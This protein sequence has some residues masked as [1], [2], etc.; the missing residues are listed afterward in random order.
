M[1][2]KGSGATRRKYRINSNFRRQTVFLITIAGHNGEEILYMPR[3][4]TGTYRSNS[5]LWILIGCVILVGVAT[6]VYV[7]PL[8]GTVA[9]V[10]DSKIT[11]AMLYDEM[12]KRVGQEALNNLIDS[13]LIMQ[14]ASMK[15]LTL[16][17]AELKTEVDRFILEQYGSEE[18]FDEVLSYYGLTR[19]QAEDEWKV[20][21][22]AKKVL[23]AGME[24]T[25][26]DLRAYFDEHK[27]DFDEEELVSLRQ[28]VSISETDAQ[29]ILDEVA[30]GGDFAEIA[31]EKSIDAQTRDLGG[32]MGWVFR[33]GLD[34][35]LGQIAFELEEGEL[36]Q[37]VETEDGWVI[38][39]VTGHK[40]ARPAVFEDVMEEV[41]AQYE[42]EKIDEALPQWLNGLRSKAQVQYK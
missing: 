6:V 9:V 24:I 10:N 31:K 11:K 39:E 1:G 19:K 5:V 14:E 37:P 22:S 30:Q 23:L 41:R 12:Y 25:E 34:E 18:Q 15:N 2:W 17:S 7:K 36:S 16:S 32:D 38:I 27:A 29:S 42:D 35:E 3:P 4:V 20:Y 13:T 8:R 33:D 28:I 26:D 40:E 21:F